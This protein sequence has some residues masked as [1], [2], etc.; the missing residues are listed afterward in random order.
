MLCA[1]CAQSIS[2]VHLFYTKMLFQR[3]EILKTMIVI[4]APKYSNFILSCHLKHL[5]F[6]VIFKCFSYFY[7]LTSRI[8]S[9]PLLE[10]SILV[11]KV[12]KRILFLQFNSMMSV[13]SVIPFKFRSCLQKSFLFSSLCFFFSFLSQSSHLILI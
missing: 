4:F 13:C 11:I 2:F 9:V 3:I 5:L 7:L 6:F 8:R 1:L 10:P 12:S